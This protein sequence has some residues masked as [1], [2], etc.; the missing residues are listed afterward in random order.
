VDQAATNVREQD[1]QPKYQQNH[2]NCP[3]HDRNLLFGTV[4]GKSAFIGATFMPAL[5]LALGQLTPCVLGWGAWRPASQS[6]GFEIAR[7]LMFRIR[8]NKALLRG[9]EL[10]IISRVI[11][12]HSP[13]PFGGG[14]TGSTRGKTHE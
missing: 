9:V 5:G 6:S 2:Q 11:S 7:N 4:V 8:S 12:F 13:R 1:Y 3:Q 10:I 14:Q